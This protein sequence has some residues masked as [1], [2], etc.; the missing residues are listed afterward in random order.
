ME[1]HAKDRVP[2]YERPG[3][4]DYGTLLDLTEAG[5]AVNADTPAG[6]A[7]TAFPIAS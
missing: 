1:D 6:I 2:S 3:V 4:T 5:L 7:N